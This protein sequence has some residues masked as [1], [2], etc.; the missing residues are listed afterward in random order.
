LRNAGSMA[1]T[2][3]SS[4]SPPLPFLVFLPRPCMKS[5]CTVHIPSP[6]FFPRFVHSTVRRH[7]G[8]ACI[9]CYAVMADKC[10]KCIR[11][12]FRFVFL[13]CEFSSNKR[14][15]NHRERK[16]KRNRADSVWAVCMC[17]QNV[18]RES[19]RA[20][21]RTHARTHHVS[22]CKRQTQRQRKAE[23]RRVTPLRKSAGEQAS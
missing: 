22:V 20:R 1:P 13:V 11:H 6:P 4:S 8:I 14:T 15:A 12:K 5:F 23:R 21:A 17:E 9:Q 3:P 7:H 19:E 18:A 10:V 2:I 16:L